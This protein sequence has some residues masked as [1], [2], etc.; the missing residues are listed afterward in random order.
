MITE[1]PIFL[2]TQTKMSL[3][4]FKE[5]LQQR[6]LTFIEPYEAMFLDKHTERYGFCFNIEGDNQQDIIE[7]LQ[8]ITTQNFGKIAFASIKFCGQGIHCCFA[9]LTMPINAL[10]TLTLGY[11]N[12]TDFSV[13]LM[14]R[15][16]EISYFMAFLDPKKLENLDYTAQFHKI[17]DWKKYTKSL[18]E[19]LDAGSMDFLQVGYYPL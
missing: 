4:Q 7:K 14:K 3:A 6:N 10:M 5:Q 9:V 12:N 8:Q 15:S 16:D 2:E 11:M 1:V 19:Y 18:L 17:E 13:C